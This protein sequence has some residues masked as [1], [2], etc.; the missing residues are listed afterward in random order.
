MTRILAALAFL[1]LIAV[2]AAAQ[3]TPARLP[4][5]D[6]GL[7]ALRLTDGSEI[8][9]QV[10]ARDDST[11]TVAGA[12][13]VRTVV[14]VRA[15][16]SWRAARGRIVGGRFRNSDPNTSR[17]FFA[18]TGRTLPRG[19]GYFADYYLFFPMV[20]VGIADRFMLAGG[21]SIVPGASSQLLYIAP[22]IG[23]VRSPNLN[24]ALGGLYVT[25]PGEAGYAGAAYGVAT[26]GSEDNAVTVVAGYPFANGNR[27][28]EPGFMVGAETRILREGKLMVEAWKLP[29][30]SEV[31][32]IV[33]FRFFG[34][35]L[36]TDFGLLRVLGAGGDGGFP[37]VPW[38][39]FAVHF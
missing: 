12:G 37:F 13:G 6:S 33:G 30:I 25:V 17:L 3:V 4:P 14:P 39:D 23:V 32:V 21:M 36:S 22:K 2:P 34:R 27:P 9:G 20:G 8:I 35:R 5:V 26:F 18:P 10:V 29:G 28:R 7:V 1:L 31:P 15:L 38:V 24:V 19:S 16:R 11:M